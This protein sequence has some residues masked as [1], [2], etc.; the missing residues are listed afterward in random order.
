MGLINYLLSHSNKLCLWYDSSDRN[1]PFDKL[2]QFYERV[3]S[4][5]ESVVITIID[6]NDLTFK[7]G[8]DILKLVKFFQ[9]CGCKIEL[10]F[11]NE[12]N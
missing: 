1:E 8:N 3:G 7:Y 9:P 12:K 2:E 10:E 11:V 4:L 5:V 6:F